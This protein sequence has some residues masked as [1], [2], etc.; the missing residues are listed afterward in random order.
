MSTQSQIQVRQAQAV[1]KSF[2]TDWNVRPTSRNTRTFTKSTASQASGDL[3]ILQV[4]DLKK[5]FSIR[6]DRFLILQKARPWSSSA[7]IPTMKNWNKNATNDF[8]FWTM[9][10][11]EYLVN[12]MSRV[13]PVAYY[14]S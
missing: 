4:K 12:Q 7:M 13:D 14:V 5:I 10:I 8:N 6:K 2:S 3:E 11:Q 9:D 1:A